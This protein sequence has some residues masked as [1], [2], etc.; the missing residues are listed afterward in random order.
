MRGN[1]LNDLNASVDLDMVWVEPGTFTMGQNDMVLPTHQVT[2]TRGFYLGKYE[3]TQAQY[4]AVMA[5]DA[6]LS[7]TPSMFGGNP[8][9]PVEKISHNDIQIFLQRLNE[10]E[11]D[12][13]LP[14]WEY[15][16][17]TEA[18]WEY[19]C[20]AGTTTMYSWGSSRDPENANWNHGNDPNKTVDVGQFSPNA[21]G[22]HDM[23]GNV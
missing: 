15:V 5:N 4:E 12:N 9:H 20:R 14:G 16:L 7:S 2:L 18:Q 3:V 21:W 23:H 13:L 19:A 17:P 22:L 1:H 10:K 11:A 8:N 6:G